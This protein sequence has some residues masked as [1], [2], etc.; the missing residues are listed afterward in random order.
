[1]SEDRSYQLSQIPLKC[2][3]QW[4]GNITLNEKLFNEKT[5][6]SVTGATADRYV[7]KKD[8]QAQITPHTHTQK[9]NPN[10]EKTT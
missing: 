2:T 1:M 10:I 6:I 7:T 8:T 5:E 3:L 9:K 4:T